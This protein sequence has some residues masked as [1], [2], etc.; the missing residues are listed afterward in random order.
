MIDRTAA[1]FELDRETRVPVEWE[2]ETRVERAES[3]LLSPHEREEDNG[4]E[5]ESKRARTRAR[6]RAEKGA[7]RQAKGRLAYNRR[8]VH[9]RTLPRDADGNEITM[10]DIEAAIG[11]LSPVEQH[12]VREC[13]HDK[14]CKTQHQIAA[15]LGVDVRTIKRRVRK[16]RVRLA[17]VLR[18][19]WARHAKRAPETEKSVSLFPV[20]A[21]LYC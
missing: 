16:I 17:A 14:P 1:T 19:K 2:G 11:T 7:R 20:S 4:E 18:V 15:E 13:L 9:R 6:T 10:A 8:A 3:Q 12:I 5:G 21:Q